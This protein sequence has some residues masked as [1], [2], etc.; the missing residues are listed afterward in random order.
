MLMI[1]DIAKG[2]VMAYVH[3]L[4]LSPFVTTQHNLILQ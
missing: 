4:G 2:F 3:G 1:T